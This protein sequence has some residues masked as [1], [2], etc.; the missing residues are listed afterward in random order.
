MGVMLVW[1]SDQELLFN[2]R[3]QFD[4][5]CHEHPKLR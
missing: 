3:G 5:G 1:N 2:M 4:L